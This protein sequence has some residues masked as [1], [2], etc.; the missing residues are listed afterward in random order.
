MAVRNASCTL[1]DCSSSSATSAVSAELVV[2]GD[3][4]RCLPRLIALVAQATELLNV[5]VILSKA[6]RLDDDSA[7]P[8]CYSGSRFGELQDLLGSASLVSGNGPSHAPSTGIAADTAASIR[9]IKSHGRSLRLPG[10]SATCGGRLGENFGDLGGRTAW[11]RRRIVEFF[12][13]HLQWSISTGEGSP[14]AGKP[15]PVVN[16]STSRF[17]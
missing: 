6:D 7:A 16:S 5:V 11:A 12:G 14:A 9:G 13:T 8:S 17:V 4:V 3:V 10:M 2:L 15:L 1:I